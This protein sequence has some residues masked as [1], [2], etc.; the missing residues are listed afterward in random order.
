MEFVWLGGLAERRTMVGVKVLLL[1]R[2]AYGSCDVSD[3]SLLCLVFFL[4]CCACWLG[5]SHG[6]RWVVCRGA[7]RLD[8][9]GTCW[10]AS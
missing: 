10:T 2:S 1:V 3:T 5:D 8:R 4:L 7:V 6:G 9:L